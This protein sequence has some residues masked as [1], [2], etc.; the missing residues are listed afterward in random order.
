MFKVVNTFKNVAETFNK[1]TGGAYGQQHTKPTPDYNNA[2]GSPQNSGV[3]NVAGMDEEEEEVDVRKEI[4]EIVAECFPQYELRRNV[5]PTTIG[6]QG[7]G[8]AVLTTSVTNSGI[9]STSEGS[10]ILICDIFSEPAPFGRTVTENLSP[11][12]M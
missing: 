2:A 6:G 5:S 7:R 11:G 12:R 1:Q 3:Q 4:E 9:L 8:P 10:I